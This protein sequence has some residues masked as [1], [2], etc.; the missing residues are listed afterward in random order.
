MCHVFHCCFS[1]HA[2]LE[3]HYSDKW[4]KSA[5]AKK[6][7][8]AEGIPVWEAEQCLVA[9][10]FLDEYPQWE[11]SSP[12]CPVILQGMF[13]HAKTTGQKEMKWAIH[14]G[15][16]QSYPGLNT[17]VEVPAIQL[18]GF[19]TT[20]EEIQELYNDIYQ[21]MSSPGPLPYGLE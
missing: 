2:L 13:A 6:W 9:D 1:Y 7:A 17:K 16:W 10:L 19:K 3:L 12:Q 4:N 18:F 14:H 21:L 8:Q 20:R 15:H 5:A 11:A